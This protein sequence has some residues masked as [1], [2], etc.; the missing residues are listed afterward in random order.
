MLTEKTGIPSA[1]SRESNEYLISQQIRDNKTEEAA[2]MV[3]AT[4]PTREATHQ[5]QA[6]PKLLRRI[7]I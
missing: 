3:P 2:D 7:D 4:L 5:A 6:M 1:Y